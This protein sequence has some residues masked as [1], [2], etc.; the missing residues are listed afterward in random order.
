MIIYIFSANLL[1]TVLLVGDCS[2]CLTGLFVH[3]GILHPP[4]NQTESPLRKIQNAH[5]KADL[6]SQQSMA[7]YNRSWQCLSSN[8]SGSHY[9]QILVWDDYQ[10]RKTAAV[11][12]VIFGFTSHDAQLQGNML[13]I[14]CTMTYLALQVLRLIETETGLDKKDW[15]PIWL[16]AQFTDRLT[17]R[18][19]SDIWRN[20]QRSARC[21]CRQLVMETGIF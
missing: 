20:C 15:L 1:W 7:N 8:K 10:L 19:K 2:T 11:L 3:R 16:S 12:A 17:D 14:F 5:S 18:L 6:N 4:R 9:S 13:I 21:Q